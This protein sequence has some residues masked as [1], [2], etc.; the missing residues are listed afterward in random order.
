M[1]VWKLLLQY[2]TESEFRSVVAIFPQIDVFHCCK[3][4]LPPDQKG[5]YLVL[6]GVRCSCAHFKSGASI[7]HLTA[8]PI[9]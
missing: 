9:L 4:S 5:T 2:Y 7:S 3:L 6:K 8:S 1:G